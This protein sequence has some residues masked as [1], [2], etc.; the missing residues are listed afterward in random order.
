MRWPWRVGLWRSGEVKNAYEVRV[1]NSE[2]GGL[3]GSLDRGCEFVVLYH[4]LFDDA[5]SISDYVAPSNVIVQLW[6]WHTLKEALIV[7][8]KYGPGNCLEG[9]MN[10]TKNITENSCCFDFELNREF[11]Q[12]KCMALRLLAS[13]LHGGGYC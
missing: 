12:Y 6:L 11:R 5:V 10:V 7:Y 8:S 3:L 2:G 1:W 4:W 9:Q 13:S